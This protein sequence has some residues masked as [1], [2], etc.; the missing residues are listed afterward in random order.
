VR[1]ILLRGFDQEIAER[2]GEDMAGRGVHFKRGVTVSSV[3]GEKEGEKVVTFSDGSS[4][5]FN[6]ILVAVGRTADTAS[7]NLDK[8]GIETNP[9]NGKVRC[10]P[11]TDRHIDENGQEVQPHFYFLGDVVEGRPELTPVAIQSG[12]YL[13][14]R[15]FPPTRSHIIDQP[16]YKVYGGGPTMNYDLIPTAVFTPLEY[17]AV[18]LSEDEAVARYGERYVDAYMSLFKPL[19]WDLPQAA[20]EEGYHPNCF[21]K[22]VVRKLR[23]AISTSISSASPMEEEV[24]GVHIL[25][26]NAGEIIQSL[27]IAMNA[28]LSPIHFPGAS[29]DEEKEEENEEEGGEKKRTERRRKGLLYM[30]VLRTVGIHPTIAEE[31]CGDNTSRSCG[32]SIEKTGC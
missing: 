8:V 30:D 13:A 24:L 7:L 21:M 6:T 19:E 22:V 9:R 11:L 32:L 18:G 25:S 23:K 14:R 3:E 28:K 1:S 4:D 16:S 15:L 10:S 20:D 2:I 29:M 17:G 12:R 27:G 31:I 5:T 26:P